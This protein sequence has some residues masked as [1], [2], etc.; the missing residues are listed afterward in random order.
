MI[1]GPARA[2]VDGEEAAETERTFHIAERSSAGGV[3]SSRKRQGADL[4]EAPLPAEQFVL[5]MVPRLP[6]EECNLLVRYV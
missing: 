3:T 2:L 1:D 5:K 4:T 6:V